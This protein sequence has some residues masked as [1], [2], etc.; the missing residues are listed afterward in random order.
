M[1]IY[2]Y[3]RLVVWPTVRAQLYHPGTVPTQDSCFGLV[4][5]YQYGITDNIE[6]FTM[7]GKSLVQE[8]RT[9]QTK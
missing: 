4:R 5:P 2:D 7:C 6:A 9:C 8:L 3:T 1:W